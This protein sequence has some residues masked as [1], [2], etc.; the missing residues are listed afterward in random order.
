MQETQSCDK[1][2]EKPLSVEKKEDINLESVRWREGG[3]GAALALVM[4][5]TQEGIEATTRRKQ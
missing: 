4:V 3:G 2:R 5:A 1:T